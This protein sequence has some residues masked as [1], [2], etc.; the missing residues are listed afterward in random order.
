MF[1]QN[2]TNKFYFHRIY[3]RIKAVKD[4]FMLVNND[5][6]SP[7]F[8]A[9][10]I[11][12]TPIT[13]SL[14]QK[15]ERERPDYLVAIQKAGEI[16]GA[17]GDPNNTKYYD[18]VLEEYN[19][20][21]YRTEIR[22][23]IKVNK[24]AFWGSFNNGSYYGDLFIHS[25]KKSKDAP[26]EFIRIREN[27]FG[28]ICELNKYNDENRITAFDNSPLGIEDAALI[29]Q[30]LKIMDRLSEIANSGNTGVLEKI[31]MPIVKK[32]MSVSE[33]IEKYGVDA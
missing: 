32:R 9:L 20:F 28:D 13:F 31:K 17:K 21:N 24:N 12:K 25:G 26:D 22:P 16:L 5:V 10:I 3:N 4:I 27:G 23:H 7:S 14:L 29:A 15:M 30:A 11:K 19:H 8:N 33:F 2:K 6:H 18:L 1:K